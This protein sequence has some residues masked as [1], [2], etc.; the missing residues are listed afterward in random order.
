MTVWDMRYEQWVEYKKWMLWCPWFFFTTAQRQTAHDLARG[1][2][3]AKP[4]Q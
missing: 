1:G 2:E 4:S 3:A